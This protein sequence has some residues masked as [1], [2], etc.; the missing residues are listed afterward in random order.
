MD[1]STHLPGTALVAVVEHL[2]VHG[3]PEVRHLQDPQS[4]PCSGLRHRK[5]GQQRNAGGTFQHFN[6]K[7]SITDLQRRGQL[8]LPGGQ[9]VIKGVAVVGIALC[10]EKGLSSSSSTR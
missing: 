7:G 3:E 9:K 1:K 4:P 2:A 5:M 6:N 8:D 10:E